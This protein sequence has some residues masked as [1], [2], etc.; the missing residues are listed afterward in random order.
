MSRVEFPKGKQKEW[1][2]K[3]I[4]NNEATEN[5]LAKI[6]KVSTRT[7]RDWKREKYKISGKTLYQLSKK[8]NT[9]IPSYTK[10]IPDYW[11]SQKGAKLGALRRM[12]LYGPPGTPE[13]RKKGGRNSQRNRKLH[14]ELYPYCIAEKDFIMP[15]KSK[16]LAEIIGIILG[17]GGVTDYQ[18]KVT[19]NKETEPEYIE[20]VLALFE[21][22]F[23][24]KCRKYY[25]HGTSKDKVCDITI[26]G[27]NL[28][29]ILIKL[30]IKKG[31]KTKHQV[32]VPKWITENSKY[33]EACLRGLIDTD[34][35]I[36]FHHHKTNGFL[37]FNLGL[38]FT[39]HSTPLLNFVCQLLLKLGFHPKRG[40]K[41]IYLYQYNEIIK[42]FDIIGTNNSHNLKRLKQFVK[43]KKEKYSSG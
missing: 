4:S 3:I 13:G 24:T 34:G 22:I 32:G 12:E 6:C 11:Y 20:F 31:N 39:S 17:D 37:C 40:S 14:P 18:L 2:L 5:E 33:S 43:Q 30:G 8:Y 38:C 16:E 19:L 23:R 10:N 1:L 28:I 7:I 29:K 25:F 35:G 27:I 42:Y 26:N 41:H 36:Y 15:E 9:K 21:K